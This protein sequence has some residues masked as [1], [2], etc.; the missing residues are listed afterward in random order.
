MVVDRARL[1]PAC[2]REVLAFPLAG[3]L[4][5]MRERFVPLCVARAAV[6]CESALSMESFWL[7]YL[8]QAE[9]V[10]LGGSPSLVPIMVRQRG[11]IE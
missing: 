2:R 10:Y 8:Q 6:R 5:K 4:K 3:K 7:R 11:A 9:R 1:A